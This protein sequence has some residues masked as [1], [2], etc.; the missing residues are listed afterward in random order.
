VIEAL[1]VEWRAEWNRGRRDLWDSFCAHE[2][3]DIEA[4]GA[5][6][7]GE[8]HV[9]LLLQVG[10]ESL[11]QVFEEERDQRASELESLV[12]VIVLGRGGE[13]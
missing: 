1:R 7:F 2:F 10:V 12:S 9:D 13:N 11:E 3:H 4:A 8:D 5:V 6:G